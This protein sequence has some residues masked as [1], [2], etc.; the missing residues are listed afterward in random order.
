VIANIIYSMLRLA[1]FIFLSLLLSSCSDF[2]N[3][4]GINEF[5]QDIPAGEYIGMAKIVSLDDK[6]ASDSKT[7][8]IKIN[9]IPRDPG[10]TDGVGILTMDDESSRFLWRAEGNNSNTWSV[11]FFKDNN[12]YSN[13]KQIFNFDGALSQSETENKLEGRLSFDYDSKISQYFVTA[14][15]LFKPVLLP[16]K[17]PITVKSGDSFEIRAEKLGDDQEKLEVVLSRTA[18]EKETEYSKPLSIESIIKDKSIHIV[19]LKTEK[20][21][22]KG[23]Y[24]IRITRD[25]EHKSNALV[26]TIN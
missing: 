22:I 16:P 24:S 18:T 13:L 17:E 14:S 4:M 8:K 11:L 23:T 21:L 5:K 7:K 19:K 10:I 20:G 6:E 9:F 15:Q 26:L 1:S 2:K 3:F 12:L 25:K